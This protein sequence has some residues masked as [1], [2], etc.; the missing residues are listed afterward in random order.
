M[1][2]M[3]KKLQS[4][5]R[6][7]GIQAALI[8]SA[9]N[10]FY[11]TG[12]SSSD[13]YLIVNPDEAVFITDGRYIEAAQN[14]INDC[15]VVLQKSSRNQIKEILNEMNAKSVAVEQSR[16]T[17][18]DYSA[19]SGTFGNDISIDATDVLDRIICELRSVKDGTEVEKIIKAQRIAEEAF[20]YICGFIKAGKSEKEVA[21]Q[22]DF[23][24]LNHGAQALSFETIAVSGKK[25]S[26]PHGVPDEKIIENGDFV[27]M[28]FGAVFDGYHSD[29]TR[30]VAVGYASDEMK[31][32]YETV[33]SAQ[34]N[35]LKELKSG[36]SCKAA[37][38]AARSVIENAGFGEYFTHS[39]GHGVG[40]E[41]HEAPNLSYLSEKILEN[42]NVVTIEP[43]IYIPGKFGVRIED[44]A[45]ITQ[46]G[47]QNL[48]DC[49]K[50]LIIL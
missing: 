19:F 43:G 17:I 42:G 21:L 14:R 36:L 48:T 41:I 40:V 46:N 30:T 25:G 2:M 27:T 34:M 12:F 45:Y 35:A 7:N 50:E 28:D 11:F 47:A 10:R 22:L 31:K 23:Y 24:M 26:M 49:P 18:S 38:G 1:F 15:R 44:M 20:S 8:I 9:E 37:D 16:M 32:V 29:M 5:L 6:K 33:L 13:G 39:T 3:I 4:E